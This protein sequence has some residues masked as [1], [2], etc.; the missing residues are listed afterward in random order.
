MDP[1]HIEMDEGKKWECS[2][3]Q[4]Q[5]HLAPQYRNAD[6][7]LKELEDTQIDWNDIRRLEEAEYF[8][9]NF[10][11]FVKLRITFIQQNRNTNH[12]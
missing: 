5:E 7:I 4:R 1:D 12:R 6:R 2:S 3:C 10:Y 11:L 9:N 8:H